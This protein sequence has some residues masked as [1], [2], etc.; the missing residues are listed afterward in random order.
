AL[1]SLAVGSVSGE[2]RLSLVIAAYLALSFG[3]TLVLTHVPIIEM[4]FV[5]SGFMLR[6]LGGAVATR[7]PPSGWFLLVCAL[8]ALMVAI[9]KR[10]T[11]LRVLGRGAG[12]HRP[13]MRWYSPG[14]L[15]V[16]ERAVAVMMIGAYLMWA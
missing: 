15:R 1:A 16:S 11:E 4:M 7:V 2:P 6:A 13:V 10:F 14:L 9:A 8:G 12:R 3:Y 5:A